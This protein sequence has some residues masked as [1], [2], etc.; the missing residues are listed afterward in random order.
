MSL[1]EKTI[2]ALNLDMHTD[3]LN[4]TTLNLEY[5]NAL[6]KMASILDVV[7]VGSR[8][9][10][11]EKY[12]ANFAKEPSESDEDYQKRLLFLNENK[13]IPSIELESE[14]RIIFCIDPTIKEL[15]KFCNWDYGLI[16]LATYKE[17]TGFDTTLTIKFDENEEMPVFIKKLFKYCHENKATDINITTMQSTL[18]I[19]LKISG[20]WTEPVGAFPIAYKNRFLIALCSMCSPNAKDYKSGKELKFRIA[21]DLDGI[22]VMF[23]ISIFPSTFGED[24]AIRKLPT[25]GALP[26]IDTLGL[27]DEAIALFKN[28]VELIQSP[29]KGGMVLITGETGS[30][31]STLLSAQVSEYLKLNKKVNTSED[32]VENK[33][34]HPFL[35][36]TE[37]GD[38][39]G[40]THMDALAGFLRL[41][42]DVIVIGECRKAEEFLAVIQASLSGH[43]TYTTYHTGGVLETLMRLKAMGIDLNLIAG[44]LKGIVSI[45]LIPKLC[46]E[47]KIKVN[48]LG[49]Y[50][51]AHDLSCPSCKGR[52]IKGVVPVIEGSLFNNKDVKMLLGVATPF[53]I[54]NELE[55]QP[56]YISMSSQINRLKNLGQICHRTKDVF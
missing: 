30:G 28:L 29:K 46:E 43:F 25:V 16:N 1:L 24:I 41:N 44:T 52:G 37:V 31:K 19:I 48:D 11:E 32:P 2:Q 54:M 13:L 7:S 9:E 8:T 5:E 45:N 50:E 35:N 42:S 38:E 3:G 36:Q 55:K 51:R 23:R 20:E 10:F 17:I 40:L 21:Q 33:H 26:N 18:S 56:E 34:P 49:H 6:E 14:R 15:D 39:S 12:M 22:N 27:S 4:I 47:C 53:E